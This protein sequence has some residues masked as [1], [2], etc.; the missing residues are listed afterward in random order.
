[1]NDKLVTPQIDEFCDEPPWAMIANV[2]SIRPRQDPNSGELEW[3]SGTA[4]FSPG[5]KVICGR[6][7]GSCWY[8]ESKISVLGRARRSKRWILLFIRIAW[9]DS[10]RV[11]QVYSSR[12]LQRIFNNKNKSYFNNAVKPGEVHRKELEFKAEQCKK[13]ADDAW[14]KYRQWPD[15]PG[16]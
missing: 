1:M 5:T 16:D 13:L 6:Q 10:F 9:L 15:G 12:L 4:H 11:K 8:D 7:I 14:A 2:V 3:L